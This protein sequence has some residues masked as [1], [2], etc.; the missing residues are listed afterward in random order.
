[1]NNEG[2]DLENVYD[3]KIAPLMDQIIAIC[4]EHKLPMFSTF[5]Y[6][7]DAT[8]DDAGLCT[9]NL[10][11]ANDR[12]LNTNVDRLVDVVLPRRTPALR[13]RVRNKEG[14]VTNETVIFP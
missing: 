13:M 14:V 3:E 7:C 9:T 1:V 10:M 12:P 8:G 5:M 2:Y 6:S 4:N 11:F